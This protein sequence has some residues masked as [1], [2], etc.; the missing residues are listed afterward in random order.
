MSRNDQKQ[1]KDFLSTECDKV[2]EIAIQYGFTAII[3]PHISASDISEAKQFKEFD[4]HADAEEKIAL[5][6][7]YME[8]NLMNGSQPIMICFKKPL[9]GGAK[10][11][12]A[13]EESYGLEIM[14]SVRSEC[15]ALIIKTAL[16]ILSDIGYKNL[17]VDINSIGDKESMGRFEREL[18]SF[19]RKSSGALPAKLKDLFKKNHIAPLVDT[20]KESESFRESAPAPIGALSDMSRANFREV[21]EYL[22]AF[23]ISYKI[24]PNLYS[25]KQ[26]A[27][28]TIFEIRGT[29]DKSDEEIRLAVGYRYNYLARKIGIKKEIP[30]IG[31]TITVKKDAIPAKKILI[32]NIKKPRFYLVQ[33]GNTAK[34]KA[35]N[36]VEMLRTER[37]PVYHSLTKDKITGQLVGAEYMK[38]TH[39]LIIGQKEAIENSIVV[40]HVITREQ[41]TVYLSDL[42]N[43]LK[44]I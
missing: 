36:V 32:K 30:S 31:I 20:S 25:N 14:G 18:L 24:K 1:E 33:L 16:A 13:T 8:H 28:H 35:L 12:K 41:E 10:R 4:Y 40:R 27:S 6:R 44:N 22:E 43:F 7:W 5:A 26:Y 29:T 39:V 42:V 2:G 19:F 38:A 11:A 17:C 3:P 21:L 34:L 15:E 37:I 9:P 23:G